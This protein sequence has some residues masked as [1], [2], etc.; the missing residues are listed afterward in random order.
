MSER[1]KLLSF[2]FDR[3]DRDIRNIKFFRGN[4]E[5]LMLED[6]CRVAHD[7]LADTWAREDTLPHAP[8]VVDA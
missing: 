1:D 5:N 7:V 8:P 4:T 3:N 2:L 6:I